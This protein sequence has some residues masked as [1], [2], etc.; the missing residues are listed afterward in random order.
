MLRFLTAIEP[1]M[2]EEVLLVVAVFYLLFAVIMLAVA[3]VTYVFQSLAIYK[4]ASRRG[5]NNP[6]LAWVPVGNVW[7]M[8]SLSDQYQYVVKGKVTN[9]RKI[10]MGLEIALVV[11]YLAFYVLAFIVGIMSGMAPATDAAATSA[12]GGLLAMVVALVMVAVAIVMTVFQ[13]ITLYDIF[14]SADPNNAVLYFV[15]SILVSITLPIL[16][17]ICRNKDGGMPPRKVAPQPQAAP[18]FVPAPECAAAPAAPV[19]EEAPVA[20]EGFA[21]P[22]EFAEEP[23]E[24]PV[25]QEESTEPTE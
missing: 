14:N 23:E 12:V 10:L 4:M 24:A 21:L 5:I 19:A 25:E 7:I 15:L 1:E 3:V 16:L 9:R 18:A 20:K 22:E 11:V 2:D 17:F 6:W 13:Y 8:G